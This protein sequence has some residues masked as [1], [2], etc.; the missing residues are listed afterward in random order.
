MSLAQ[1]TRR[2]AADSTQHRLSCDLAGLSQGV[3][4]EVGVERSQTCVSVTAALA[5]TAPPTM[6]ATT[7][8][9][10]NSVS[11]WRWA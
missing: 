4:L 10:F 8:A 7:L 1:G 6:F 9:A 3:L 11:R 5:G 2:L